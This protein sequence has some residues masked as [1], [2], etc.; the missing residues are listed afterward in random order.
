MKP[1]LLVHGIASNARHT[2]G[3]PGLLFKKLKTESMYSFLLSEGYQPGE[4]LF[5]FSYPTL[6]PI[7]KSAKRLKL[8]IA[9]AR[10]LSGSPTMDLVTFSLGGII[11]KYYTASPFYQNDIHKLIMIAP[12]FLGSPR[13][14]FCKTEFHK[15]QSDLFLPGDSRAW[16]PLILGSRH[17]LLLELAC[18]PFPSSIQTAI[19]AMKLHVDEKK[20]PFQSR[21]AAWI[22]EG[23]QTVPVQST[24]VAANRHYIVEDDYAPRKIHGFL[25]AHREIQ[26]IV[27]QELQGDGEGAS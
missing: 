18:C 8:E 19:I 7:L 4:N 23:D 5:W 25:P 13:A 26:K 24:E 21:I 16:T 15:N 17:P 3:V 10:A 2:F 12:P 22:G 11:G 9:R 20:H 14:D 6:D 27:L 1:L